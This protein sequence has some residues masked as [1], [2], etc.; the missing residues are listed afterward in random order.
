MADGRREG[1]ASCAR[2]WFW[3]MKGRF[4]PRVERL[5]PG[6]EVRGRNDFNDGIRGREDPRL[7]VV[8]GEDEGWS[9]IFR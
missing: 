4:W 2:W 9:V 8:S 5:G 1:E 7:G 3:I 6:S